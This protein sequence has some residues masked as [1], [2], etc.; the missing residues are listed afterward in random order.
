MRTIRYP[1]EHNSRGDTFKIYP[2]ADWHVGAKAFDEK[3]F[4]EQVKTIENDPSAYWVGLG[5]YIDGICQVGDKRYTPE[6]LAPWVLGNTDLMDVQAEYAADLVKPIAHKC[7]GLIEGNHDADSKRY[8]A[9][10]IYWQFARMIANRGKLDVTQLAFGYQGF[11]QIPFRRV[12]KTGR[13]CDS[14]QLTLYLQ[15]GFGGGRLPGGHAL[16]LGR[17]MSDYFADIC[18]MGHRHVLH[19]LSNNLIMPGTTVPQVRRRY[20]AF[21]P[22]YL[23]TYL[24]PKISGEP[25]DAYPEKLAL[26][27]LPRGTFPIEVYPEKRRIKFA[28]EGDVTGEMV[29]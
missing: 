5:D 6:T 13:R 26:P 25:I 22:S 8:Y 1:I 28:I 7:M 18:L 24:E 15:H 4:K 23:G 29:S 11:L 10:S 20:G 3:L 9:R 19:F 16:A 17:I 21:V 2:L 12:A 14:W 27:G